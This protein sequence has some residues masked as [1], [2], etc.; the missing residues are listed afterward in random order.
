M[1]ATNIDCLRALIDTCRFRNAALSD[2]LS[3]NPTKQSGCEIA[4][5]SILEST[6]PQAAEV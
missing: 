6:V 1:E 5:Q 4:A 3:I 2:D